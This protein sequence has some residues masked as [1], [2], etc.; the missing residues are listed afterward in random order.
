MLIPSIAGEQPKLCRSAA[1]NPSSRWLRSQERHSDENAT[2]PPDSA[3]FPVVFRDR[4]VLATRVRL[5]AVQVA[6]IFHLATSRN[7]ATTRTRR[8]H[9]ASSWQQSLTGMSL[10]CAPKYLPTLR[11]RTVNERPDT[12][13]TRA[14]SGLCRPIC[15]DRVARKQHARCATHAGCICGCWTAPAKPPPVYSYFAAP[16]HRG[17]ALVCL[18]TCV[19]QTSVYESSF[20]TRAR[21][22]T[23]QH[24][25]REMGSR[26]ERARQPRHTLAPGARHARIAKRPMRNERPRG[27]TWRGTTC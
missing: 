2:A 18:P 27:R 6:P 20:R 22:R 9:P 16:T 10:P 11:I 14:R 26:F 24:G 5:W 12:L 21:S 15:A 19:R 13:A 23:R 17:D 7:H 3:A 1:C 25:T 8:V 4:Y